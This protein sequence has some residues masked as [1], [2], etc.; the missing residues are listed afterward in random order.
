[1]SLVTKYKK[2][3]GQNEIKKMSLSVQCSVVES[4]KFNGKKIWVVR[5]KNVDQCFLS[6]DVSK[7]IG[8]DDDDKA[9]R[10]VQTHVPGKYRMR[11][12]DAQNI[13]G[14]KVDNEP[15]KKARFY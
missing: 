13:S 4:F 12:E 6:I 10:A 15:L 7:A 2:L 3:I 9:R 8:Y 5:M 1:M 14:R 11:L